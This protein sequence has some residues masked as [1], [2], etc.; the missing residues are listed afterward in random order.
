MW[1]EMPDDN[2][3]KVSIKLPVAQLTALLWGENSFKICSDN[4]DKDTQRQVMENTPTI[5]SFSFFYPFRLVFYCFWSS[6]T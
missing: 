4:N 6:D 1:E 3:C 2:F 5:F